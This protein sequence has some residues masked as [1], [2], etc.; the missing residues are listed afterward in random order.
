MAVRSAAAAGGA[1]ARPLNGGRPDLTRPARLPVPEGRRDPVE[2]ADGGLPEVE[3]DEHAAL[4]WR[5]AGGDPAQ[6]PWKALPLHLHSGGCPPRTPQKALRAVR[7][8][9]SCPGYLSYLREECP[10]RTGNSHCVRSCDALV[11]TASIQS[12]GRSLQCRRSCRTSSA[13]SGGSPSSA[14]A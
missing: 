14:R 6:F 4:P 7:L 11:P 3:V 12:E 10:D 8:S 1:W 13:G 5:V 2:V 9:S